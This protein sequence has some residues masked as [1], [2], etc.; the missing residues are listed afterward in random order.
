MLKK[1]NIL[2]PVKRQW[3]LTTVRLIGNRLETLALRGG[4]ESY[5]LGLDHMA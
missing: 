2:A 4:H 3:L 5:W 1:V